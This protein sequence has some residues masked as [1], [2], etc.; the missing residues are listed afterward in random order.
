MRTTSA[1][2][3]ALVAVATASLAAGLTGPALAATVSAKTTTLTIHAAKTTVKEHTRDTFTGMLRAGKSP[4]S[5]QKIELKQRAYGATRWSQLATKT[6]SSKGSV[7]FTVT[8]P[9]PSKTAKSHR[10]QYEL[11]FSG[12]KAYR[13]SHS[14]IVTVTVTK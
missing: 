3:T 8:P 12:T 7:T 14:G 5:G 13:A 9:A 6:T 1:R 11:V 10:E 2:R 4:V